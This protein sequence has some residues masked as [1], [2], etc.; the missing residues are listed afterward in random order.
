MTRDEILHTIDEHADELRHL[1]A[2]GLALFGSHA[3]G[4]ASASSDVDLIVDLRPKT[5]DAYMDVKLSLERL[6]GRRVDLVLA[7][8]LKPRLRPTILAEAIHASRL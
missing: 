6:L 7:D 5:F 8:A 2:A 3:R 4:E 1:G